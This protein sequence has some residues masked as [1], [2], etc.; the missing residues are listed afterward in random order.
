[1]NEITPNDTGV[2]TLHHK[3]TGTFWLSPSF[4][5]TSQTNPSPV[6]QIPRFSMVGSTRKNSLLVEFCTLCRFSLFLCLAFPFCYGEDVWHKFHLN[7]PRSEFLFSSISFYH[8]PSH[9]SLPHQAFPSHV[10]LPLLVLFP[11]L[12]FICDSSLINDPCR[13]Y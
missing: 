3:M 8:F 11:A 5:T 13:F 10:S 6:S 2:S 4:V 9:T 1:M 12:S 7:T